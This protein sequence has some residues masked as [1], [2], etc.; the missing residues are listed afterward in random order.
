[1][2]QTGTLTLLSSLFNP[3]GVECQVLVSKVFSS[4][5]SY[6]HC[7]YVNINCV[8]KLFYKSEFC[9]FVEVVNRLFEMYGSRGSFW[10]VTISIFSVVVQSDVE[11]CFCFSYV[12]YFTKGPFHQINH[13][14]AFTGQFVEN[15]KRPLGLIAFVSLC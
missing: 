9:M 6:F 2:Q 11:R 3:F 12:L 15:F 7:I 4:F 14:A 5:Q 8:I 13:K 10:V 1:M